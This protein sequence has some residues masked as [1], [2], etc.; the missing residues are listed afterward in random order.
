MGCCE[1]PEQEYVEHKSMPISTMS[2]GLEDR[3]KGPRIVYFQLHG[4]AEAIRMLLSHA[5]VEFE[6]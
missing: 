5:K 2:A 6:D 4:K 3:K 1:S